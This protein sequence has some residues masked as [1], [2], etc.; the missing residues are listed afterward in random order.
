MTTNA[1]LK[2]R[3][4]NR[5]FVVGGWVSFSDPG[6]AETFAMSGFDF[7][8]ID[9][10]H[11]TMTLAE[12]KAIITACHAAGVE[13]LPRPVSHNNDFMKPLLEAGAD[14]LLFPMVESL[15]DVEKL[16]ESFYYTPIGQRSYGVNRAHHYGLQFNRYIESWNDNGIFI[17]QIESIKGVENIDEI[18]AHPMVDAVMV[19]PYDLSGSLGVPGDTNCEIVRDACSEIIEACRRVGKGC[20]TQIQNPTSKNIQD[21]LHAGYTFT[22]LGSDL[23]ILSEW[24]KSTLEIV[25]GLKN[26]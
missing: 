17:P 15:V 16:V 18:I 3:I 26:E 7:V 24:A 12:A 14:G 21:A 2:R 19:G 23:F 13:C 9:L 8:A 6:I 4:R 25:E 1:K 20:C 22:F 10:E 5:D 11:T